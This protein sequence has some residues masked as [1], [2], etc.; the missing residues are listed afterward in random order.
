[1]ENP[2]RYNRNQSIELMPR[3]RGVYFIEN[4]REGKTYI[5]SSVDVM[6]RWREHIEG[7]NNPN[8][9]H[10]TNKR[11]AI[12]WKKYGSHA[13]SFRFESYPLLTLD[14]LQDLETEK[15]QTLQP[16]YNI[17]DKF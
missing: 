14:E 3:L 13:F 9:V 4:I 11:L 16:F 5:G 7:C 12:D 6:A 1:M 10:L 2:I 8:K 17:K 15:I